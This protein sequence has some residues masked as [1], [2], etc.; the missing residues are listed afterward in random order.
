[1]FLRFSS[2]IDFDIHIS[3]SHFPDGSMGVE[4]IQVYQRCF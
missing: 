2:G 3:K 1:M 4:D